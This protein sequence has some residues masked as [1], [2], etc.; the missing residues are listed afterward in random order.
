MR[1]CNERSTKASMDTEKIKTKKLIKA[2]LQIHGELEKDHQRFCQ[3]VCQKLT[4]KGPCSLGDFENDQLPM[5]RLKRLVKKRPPVH[6]DEEHRVDGVSGLTLRQTPHK[7]EGTEHPSYALSGWEALQVPFL[8]GSETHISSVCKSS[9]R[10]LSFTIGP[11]G[12]ETK[13]EEVYL[14]FLPPDQWSHGHLYDS[15]SWSHFLDGAEAAE[16]YLEKNSDHLAIPLA[17]AYQF[18]RGVFAGL[19]PLFAH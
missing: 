8:M 5:R 4:F 15:S 14:S 6:F 10:K 19:Y 9:G 7:I 2:W 16:D 3:L 12:Y 18:S 1:L 11:M 13:H 17:K